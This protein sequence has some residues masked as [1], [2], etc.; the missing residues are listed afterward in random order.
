MVAE[1]ELE[2]KFRELRRSLDAI[3]EVTEPPKNILRILGH[4]RT[5]RKWNTLLAYFLDPS[6]PHGFGSYLLTELLDTIENET[7]EDI[8]YIHRDIEQ[9]EV[10]TEVISPQ[11]N[12]PDIVIRVPQE[13]FVCIESKVEAPEKKTHKY[14]EDTHIGNEEKNI[15]PEDGAYYIFL[16]KASAYDSTTDGFEDLYWRHVVEAFSEELK[17]SHGKYPERSVSQ[18]NDFLSTITEVTKMGDDDFT[19]T[20]KEK[21]QILAEYRDDI[22]ELFD[23]TNSLRERT[24]EEWTELFRNQVD[25]ELWTEDWN[26]HPDKW[27]N[28]YKHGWYLDGDLNPTTDIQETKGNDGIRLHFQHLIRKKRSFL[29]GE[30]TYILCC[31]VRVKVRDEF[32]RLF[33]SD[34]W[35]KEIEPILDKH[36]ITNRKNKSE[37]TRKKYDVDQSR[38]P[39]SYFET[40]T[41]AFEEHLELAEVVDEIIA[42]AR[43]NVKGSE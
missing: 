19:E 29:E 13:W 34:R 26:T 15:Y 2:D 41:T 8:G 3:P 7:D 39:E 11:G 12:R 27:G 40:L 16:S 43:E 1:N 37:Y 23:A 6:Q 5:E 18:L 24:I 38:L 22:D 32:Y 30:L 10:D 42:E 17:L 28:I 9:V 36:D 33:T 21:V 25:E 35:Q 4:A 20:Q 31:N 14:I